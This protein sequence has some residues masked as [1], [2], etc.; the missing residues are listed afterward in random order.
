MKNKLQL[1]LLATIV[2]IAFSS[3]D[4]VD[5]LTEFDVKQNFETT[6]NIKASSQAAKQNQ[7]TKDATTVWS[8]TTTINLDENAEISKN[9]DLIERVAISSLKYEIVNYS[10]DESAK[11]TDTSI[12]FGGTTV[13]IEDTVLKTADAADTKFTVSDADQLSAIATKLKTD[14]SLTITA[15][16]KVNEQPVTFGIKLYINTTVTIDVL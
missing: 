12:D 11:I 1:F 16:G 10:G 2:A 9:L 3:C 15:Q 13:L 5:K 14:K 8:Q 4:E 6:L 7:T